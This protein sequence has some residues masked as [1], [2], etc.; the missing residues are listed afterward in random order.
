MASASE[1]IDAGVGRGGKR[2]VPTRAQD[3][4]QFAT[5]EAGAADD[6]YFHD[7]LS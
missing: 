4:D 1:R 5:D 6:D 3:I 7:L 2:L